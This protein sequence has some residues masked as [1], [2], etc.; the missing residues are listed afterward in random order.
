MCTLH[1][2]A[3]CKRDETG[4]HAG[5]RYVTRLMHAYGL[6]LASEHRFSETAQ[7]V[8]TLQFR[9]TQWL[10]EALQLNV[11]AESVVPCAHLLSSP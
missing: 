6:V 4:G 3:P 9:W 7:L 10:P 5:W 2:F 11:A 1:V 8:H